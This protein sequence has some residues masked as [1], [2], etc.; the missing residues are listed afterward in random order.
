MGVNNENLKISEKIKK[1]EKNSGGT[2]MT[3]KNNNQEEVNKQDKKKSE[4]KY[5]IIEVEKL[6][7]KGI[8]R[9]RKVVSD[10]NKKS[11]DRR[12]T[13]SYLIEKYIY[14]HYQP[15]DEFVI[16]E[17]SDHLRSLGLKTGQISGQLNA[18]RVSGLLT[19]RKPTDEE[20]E[21]IGKGVSIWKASPKLYEKLDTELDYYKKLD[22][23]NEPD[24]K[25]NHK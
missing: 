13:N 5:K 21:V 7:I 16:S 15:T 3:T 14:D 22:T 6:R 12:K 2:N 1:E 25:S 17:M 8:T 23:E 11:L 4:L 9:Q 10:S 20:A 24:N 18:K 19:N